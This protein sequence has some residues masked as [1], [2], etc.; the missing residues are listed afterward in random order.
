M[1]LLAHEASGFIRVNLDSEVLN[2]LAPRERSRLV[3]VVIL[4]ENEGILDVR[5]DEER[6]EKNRKYQVW[7]EF[8]TW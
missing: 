2:S 5:G 1:L 8:I 6:N 4:L 3:V 7:R